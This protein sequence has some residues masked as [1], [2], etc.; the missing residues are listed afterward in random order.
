[1][2]KVPS[3]DLKAQY[4]TIRSEIREAVDCVCESQRFILGAE[5]A[6]LEEEVAAMCDI[7][8]GIGM[9][10]GTDALLAALMAIG[11]KPGDEVITTTYTFFATAGVI[12]RLGARPIFVDI[13]PETFNLDTAAV[14][15]KIGARTRAIIP[16]HLFGRSVDMDPIREAAEENGIF[17]IEDAAQAIGAKDVRGR[18]AGTIGHIG[19][20][21]FF[22]GKNLGAFGDAGMAVTNDE[23]L[24][25]TLR[26][27]RVHG[28]KPKYH[29]GT[30]GGN[31]RLDALQAAIL[32]VK[33]KYLLPWTEA[34]RNNAR[35]YRLL[36]DEMGLLE[37]A[38]LP[39]DTPGHI[40]NQF[41]VRFPDRDHLQAFLRERGVE[42]QIYYPLPLH[43]QKCFQD[44]GYQQ[45]DF[46]HAEA[47]ARDSLALPIHP[48]LTEVQR[49]YVVD[50]VK[51]FYL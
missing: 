3:L 46:P 37:W 33:L 7:R 28:G 34:R 20:F 19:G 22:P 31:F 29:H 1:M 25:E 50:Q 35:Q 43:L 14:R 40:Y 47:A 10:S 5:V 32:R 6:G 36:F 4:T 51:E 30:I 23:G 9:S 24:A 48:E 42:S 15:A 21:S 18:R 41:V 16:V 11:V 13:D 8:F 45:G 49:R 26:I 39:E 2:I 17:V 27:L 44:L 38:S 12:V